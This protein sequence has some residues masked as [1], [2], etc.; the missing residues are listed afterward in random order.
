MNVIPRLI[1]A[2]IQELWDPILKRWG[3][4]LDLSNFGELSKF[5]GD[6]S[7]TFSPLAYNKGLI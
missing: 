1:E 7:Q 2:K 5:L 3:L 6:I 4:V